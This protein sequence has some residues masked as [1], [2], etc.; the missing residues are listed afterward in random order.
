MISVILSAF[1]DISDEQISLGKEKNERKKMKKLEAARKVFMETMAAQASALK[2]E[3]R[4]L[5]SPLLA[6][7]MY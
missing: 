1:A 4:H 2:K 5:H 7:R 6:R 3:A